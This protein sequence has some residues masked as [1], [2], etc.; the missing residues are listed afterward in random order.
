M[1]VLTY[2]FG[3]GLELGWAFQVRGERSWGAVDNDLLE[4]INRGSIEMIAGGIRR[5]FLVGQRNSA[6]PPPSERLMPSAW[7]CSFALSSRG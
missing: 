3:C 1:T 4:F 6:P 5:G 7:P 2:D